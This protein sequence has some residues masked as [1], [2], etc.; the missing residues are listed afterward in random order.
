MEQA[1]ALIP[2]IKSVVVP[3]L[4][5]QVVTAIDDACLAM[6]NQTSTA[7]DGQT[8]FNGKNDVKSRFLERFQLNFDRLVGLAELPEVNLLDYSNL[9]L[10]EEGDLEAII[11]L[12]GMV[13]HARNS[14]IS[15]YLAFST[16][17]DALFYGTH[18]D[19]SNNPMDPEQIGDA[20][21]DALRPLELSS[22]G[23]LQVYRNFNTQVFHQL[24][25]VLKKANE[26]LVTEGIMADLDITARSK[27]DIKGRRGPPRERSDPTD[28]A[29]KS[30]DDHSDATQHNPQQMYS[31]IQQLMQGLGN[32]AV[33]QAPAGQAGAVAG[34]AAHL[35][36]NLQ[37]G[38]LI[39]G[40]KVELVA[41]DKLLNLLGQLEQVPGE[42]AQPLDLGQAL[43]Q[44]LEKESQQANAFKAVDSKA[45]DVI[46]LITLL[47]EAIWDDATVPI[48]I[49][50]LIGRT[51]I[52]VLKIA[53]ED[54][55]FFDQEDH[56]A[57][58]FINELATAGISW[59]DFDKLEQ[60]PMYRK[61][62]ELVEKLVDGYQGEVN[63]IG[64][65]LA[66][67]RE[68][69]K[70]HTEQDSEVEQRLRDADA[71]E[72][73]L[74]EIRRYAHQKITERILDAQTPAAIRGFLENQFHKFLVEVIVREGPGGNSWKPIMNTIDVL[75]WTVQRDKS[76][77][78]RE[79]FRK[80]NG[81]LLINLN[82]SMQVAGIDK[83]EANAVLKKIQLAQKEA[84]E[85]SQADPEPQIQD[86]SFEAWMQAASAE[87]QKYDADLPE[88]DEHLQ[89]VD[90]YP[91]GIWMEFEID[92][93]HSIRCTL[94]GKIASIDKYIFVNDQGVK[95]IEKSRMGLARELKAGTVKV[96]SASPLLD[97]AMET[98]IGRLR[99]TQEE[100][101][102]SK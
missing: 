67:F 81:R 88:D 99:E 63:Y 12:E 100:A 3:L 98:V 1:K 20:F 69:K 53:L 30:A 74:D 73:R 77:S 65:L 49:K 96:I 80:V 11:A 47:Y 94:A 55:H 93:N 14:D 24:E 15:E 95:V 102:A 13:A 4:Q 60:D 89:E 48:P 51:Q 86:D 9:S 17:L 97:R 31:M 22:H 32:Q 10:V 41:D 57:H 35:Q 85:Q 64:D 21:K 83:D 23:L 72:Q 61:M 34:D 54:P 40:Q 18:I 75:L 70:S 5:E 68:F 78:E 58:Q 33:A 91:L 46:H 6:R 84:L 19:E 27:E 52:T 66:Q 38:M 36:P 25:S 92:E 42:R 45:S 90:R 29:F 16:R 2:K 7:M 62:H 28:R 76:E 26:L 43:G 44:L 56:P 50:E 82:K 79:R 71:R 8:L 39:G 101:G 37:P 87:A 59:T